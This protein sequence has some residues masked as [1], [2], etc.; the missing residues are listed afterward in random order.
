[1]IIVV[2]VGFLTLLERKLLRLVQR[3]KGPEKAILKGLVLPLLDGL[4]LLKK[5][6]LI[7]FKANFILLSAAS[8]LFFVIS[9]LSWLAIPIKAMENKV[10]PLF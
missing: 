4:K 2:S 6:K 10:S 7:R 8:L 3:R 9:L 1:M 5:V